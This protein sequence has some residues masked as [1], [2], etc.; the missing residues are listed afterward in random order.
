MR[1]FPAIIKVARAKKR[2]LSMGLR[3]YRNSAIIKVARAKKRR[4]ECIFAPVILSFYQEG[5]DIVCKGSHEPT[6]T[7]RR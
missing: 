7:I 5:A 3:A 4:T 1:Y 2:I 6:I